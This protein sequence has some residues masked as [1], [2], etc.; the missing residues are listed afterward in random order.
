M[1][2]TSSKF[3]PALWLIL[4]A[5][6]LLISHPAAAS[7]YNATTVQ[8]LRDAV[9]WANQTSDGCTIFI[10]PGTYTLNNGEVLAMTNFNVHFIGSG[11]DT[12]IQKTGNGDGIT[13]TNTNCSVQNLTI[14]ADPAA[15][16]GSGIVFSGASAGRWVQGCWICS[17]PVSGVRFLG[18]SNAPQ[19]TNSVSDCLFSDNRGDQLYLNY[20][21]DF[22]IR[23]N[24][25]QGYSSIPTSG[26]CLDNASAGSVAKNYCF[27]NRVG[28]KMLPG[29]HYNRVESNRFDSNY[30]EGLVIG[31][32]AAG[33]FNQ[34][35]IFVGNMFYNNSRESYGIYS[36]AAAYNTDYC[37]FRENQVFVSD[38]QSFKHDWGLVLSTAGTGCHKWIVTTNTFRDNRSGTV[39]YSGS[40][41]HIVADNIY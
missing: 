33:N 26:I 7:Y 5:G 35:S 10:A 27:G 1:S 24:Y 34:F 14:K 38:A 39:S 3:A 19:S 18:P 36:A 32:T 12:V 13:F 6:A 11:W 31:G 16:T 41:G 40:V 37:M 8:Q 28:M 20:S 25:F 29:C 21:H 23:G 30:R 9:T 17:F 4:W 22:Y 2:K 15:T